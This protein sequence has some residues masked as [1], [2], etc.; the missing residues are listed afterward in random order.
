MFFENVN[1]KV[2]TSL[3][4][5]LKSLD[6]N[7]QRRGNTFAIDKNCSYSSL[8][9]ETSSN[10]YSAT[11]QNDSSFSK[12]LRNVRIKNKNNL[13]ITQL[14]INSIRNKFDI[15]VKEMSSLIDIFM[16]SETKLDET[17]PCSQFKLH[18]YSFPYRLDRNRNGGGIMLF[19]KEDIP[20]KLIYSDK[21]E[22]DFFFIE[23]NLRKSK[24]LICCSYNSHFSKIGNHLHRIS[25][26]LDILATKY[27]KLFFMGDFNCEI[28][29]NNFKHFCDNYNL[30]SLIT[31]ATCF[32]NPNKPS[33][34]DLMLTN[35]KH[36]F[37]KSTTLVSGL[38]DFHRLTLTVLKDNFKKLD[39]RIAT[40]RDYRKFSCEVFGTDLC[41]IL[42]TS[43]KSVDSLE[44]D[45]NNI[46][47]LLN[48][49]APLKRKY[50]RGNES[51]FMN[52]S[53]KK[54]IMQRTRLRN[55]FL[56]NRNLHNRQ[57]YN[58]QRNLC[59]R[60]VRESKNK[61]FENLDV[62]K[63]TDNRQF[64]RTTKPYLS[65]KLK[66]NDRILL[67][68]K[69]EIIV[70][71]L[72]CAKIFN[73]FFGNITKRL[74]LQ[75]PPS[76]S[77]DF[78]NSLISNILKFNNHVSIKAIKL[79]MFG[80][81]HKFSFRKVS[82][83]E[84]KKEILQLNVSKASQENDIPTKIVLMYV[85]QFSE[86]LKDVFNDSI[87]NCQFPNIFKLA[88]VTP[89][90]K[91][92]DKSLKENYRP[93]SILPNL[94]KIFERL[95]SNQISKYFEPILS[96]FQ[97]GFRKNFSAQ[98][99]L[100]LIL[101]K[102]KASLDNGDVFGALLTD[103][104]KAFDCISHELLI[105]KLDAYHFDFDS[106]CYLNDYLSNRKQR[107]K[108]SNKY[109]FWSIILSG[110]PQGS[111]LGPL[112]FNIYICDLFYIIQEHEFVSYADDNTPFAIG[113]SFA[114]VRDNLEA[115]WNE[116]F[117]WLSN[118]QMHGNPDKSHFITNQIDSS[119]KLNISDQTI[120][121]CDKVKL[122]G[123]TFDNKLTFEPH[124]EN[125][126]KNASSKLHALSR[127]TP[128]MSI[129]QRKLLMNAFF[130]SHFSYCPLIW[131]L[132]SRT[133]NCRINRLH[134]R[135]LRIV[136]GDKSSSFEDLLIKDKSL[137]IHQQNIHFLAIEMFKIKQNISPSLLKDIF[138]ENIDPPRNLRNNRSFVIRK[139]N[140][141]LFGTHSLSYL[142]PKIWEILPNNLKEIKSLPNFK[143]AIK[144]W[145]PTDCPCRL[146]LN[147]I[148][149]V[150]FI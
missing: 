134:E 119:L 3:K 140:T 53:L 91:K 110:V 12:F 50:I 9:L 7:F 27:D 97:C 37:K 47:S 54:E 128:Y 30:E 17:F 23:I 88:D 32:K 86:Y 76:N 68:E 114:D 103:L 5:P 136:Y 107:T 150:G 38:S 81:N 112:L 105:A 141:T 49:H 61:Y 51:P 71:D 22:K 104:S 84:V 82:F 4:Q 64:W 11:M 72:D 15:F 14:N 117:Q 24:W 116:F 139:V 124:I 93:I 87:D 43:R 115:I 83:C 16:I 42:E 48:L 145:V 66:S 138:I 75:P 1:N 133:Q 58:K 78:P 33:C 125:L 35:N 109:S 39:P 44:F 26:E 147:Y 89:I 123:V 149:G 59:V 74:N 2:N 40:Y 65:D 29:N 118:N 120:S 111:I 19:I 98:H 135:C 90:F 18:G 55:K 100:M 28:Q 96:K 63:I 106:L 121:N 79:K 57:A 52:K 94:S 46:L 8:N 113:K 122:L 95:L 60:L 108:V 92:G 131:M 6:E 126:C 143:S 21:L 102:W 69:N 20:S 144:A 80:T 62:K 70:S 45:I 13:I 10:E 67:A 129:S 148:Y 36:Q 25:I 56:K 31:S 146:C 137:T 132:H 77:N 73:D 127:I 142:G 130:T 41:T 101:E 85:D 99:C 34:I